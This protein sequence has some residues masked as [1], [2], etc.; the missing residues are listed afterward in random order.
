MSLSTPLPSNTYTVY[1]VYI[2]FNLHPLIRTLA[3][4]NNGR[5][6]SRKIVKSTD[7]DFAQG[8]LT[9]LSFNLYFNIRKQRWKLF[10]NYPIALI[11]IIPTCFQ[12]ILPLFSRN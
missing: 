6:N 5:F 2:Y 10:Q 1:T 9:S 3:D 11:Q 4:L 12:L 8:Q 7:T